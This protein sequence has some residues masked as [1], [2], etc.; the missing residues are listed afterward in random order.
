MKGYERKGSRKMKRRHTILPYLFILVF[1]I[2]SA[3]F[4]Y[5]VATSRKDL[6]EEFCINNQSETG[7]F[8]DYN[9][10]TSETI[11]E[12][13][14]MANLF[15]LNEI[16][17]TLE[18]IDDIAGFW[19]IDRLNDFVSSEKNIPNAYYALEGAILINS[20]ANETAT[21]NNAVTEMN[22]LYNVTS[23]GYNG[24]NAPVSTLSDTYFAVE[25]L[26][27]ASTFSS[28]ANFSSTNSTDIANFVSL[29]FPW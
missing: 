19:F 22:N 14:S 12:F 8:K 20:T 18:K 9:N 17:P 5:S 28:S 11:T 26:H 23:H 13:T 16:D 27:L 21:V 24:A 3:N 2:S 6:L 29:S 15:I 10:A 7:G 25:F 4:S 1:I